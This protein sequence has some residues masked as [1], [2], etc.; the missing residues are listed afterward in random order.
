MSSRLP[1]NSEKAF[2]RPTAEE[3]TELKR[4][5]IEARRLVLKTVHHARAGHVGGPLSAAEILVSL[6]FHVLRIDPARPRWEDRDRFI[7]SKGHSSIGLYSVM[8]L[9]GFFPLEELKTFDALD[10]RLQAHPDMSLLPG[11]DMS[12]GSLGQG[13]APGIGMALAARSLKKDFHVYVLIGDG[14]AQEG[15]IW[16]GSFVAAR[17]GLDNLTA[18]LDWNGLQQYGWSTPEGYSSSARLAAVENPRAKWEAFG[19]HVVEIDGHEPAQIVEALA[20]AREVKGKPTM[21]VARTVK[22][23]G[24][25]FMENNFA[26]HSKPITDQDLERALAELDQWE[27]SL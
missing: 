27:A 10:S 25:S 20:Q 2:Q 15:E 3:A 11:L 6:Y 18:I 14:D 12:T 24:V 5:A 19:W 17:Y 21:I 26:W 7:M 16:E 22:G 4:L 1:L 8:A 9:R 23:K 13:L